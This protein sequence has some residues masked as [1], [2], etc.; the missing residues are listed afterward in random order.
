MQNSENIVPA[1]VGALVTVLLEI[2][3]DWEVKKS[4]L[5]AISNGIISFSFAYYL[6]P[7]LIF[8]LEVKYPHLSVFLSNPNTISLAGFIGGIFG[9]KIV[10]LSIY[11]F[12]NY[13]KGLI[14]KIGKRFLGDLDAPKNESKR[15]F[16]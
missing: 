4:W 15:R 13:A 14:E 1:F 5:R 10:K 12:D 3:E 8:Y 16:K 7:A 9:G 6:V 2:H 11:L